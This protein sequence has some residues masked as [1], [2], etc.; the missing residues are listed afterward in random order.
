MTTKLQN[1]ITNTEQQNRNLRNEMS[2][3]NQRKNRVIRD[4]QVTRDE[5][6]PVQK[7]LQDIEIRYNETQD[8]LRRAKLKKAEVSELSTLLNQKRSRL[9]KLNQSISSLILRRLKLLQLE[10]MK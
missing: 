5:L 4:I 8:K 10:E 2:K 9:Q 7:L 3:L 6:I 1:I